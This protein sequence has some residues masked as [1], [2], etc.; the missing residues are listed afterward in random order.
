MKTVKDF[1]PDALKRVKISELNENQFQELKMLA[2][3]F[4]DVTL[5]GDRATLRQLYE[6]SAQAKK[7]T[8]S[9]MRK[10]AAENLEKF[11]VSAAAARSLY[12][13]EHKKTEGRQQSF[14]IKLQ[15]PE[16]EYTKRKR[17]GHAGEAT[18]IKKV[19]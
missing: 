8:S 16:Q 5:L 12:F 2:T 14:E 10:K 11:V 6:A 19:K 4:G 9:I 17:K 15:A 3:Q 18:I 1:A 7:K 13:R